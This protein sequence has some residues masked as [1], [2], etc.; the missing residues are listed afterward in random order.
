MNATNETMSNPQG[1]NPGTA[2]TGEM[3]RFFADVEDLLRRVTSMDDADVARLRTRV[4]GS[5]TSARASVTRGAN[6]VRESAGD[7]ADTTDEYVRRRPW[8]VAGVAMVAGALLGAALF[9]QTRR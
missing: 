1:M 5:L 2:P 3:G 7:I 6:R 9:S 4:E 8:T